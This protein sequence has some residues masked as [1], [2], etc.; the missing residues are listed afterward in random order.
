[1]TP[2]RSLDCSSHGDLGSRVQGLG[3]GFSVWGRALKPTYRLPCIGGPCINPV[4]PD[5]SGYKDLWVAFFGSL[6]LGVTTRTKGLVH[7]NCPQRQ[8]HG[9]P[10]TPHK[11][12]PLQE[13]A[14]LQVEGRRRRDRTINMTVY[15]ASA[16]IYSCTATVQVSD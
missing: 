10:Y 11:G 16:G 13:Q 15:A 7:A 4:D 8:L 5:L 12:G 1:M 2:V 6:N 9:N 3:F 14:E